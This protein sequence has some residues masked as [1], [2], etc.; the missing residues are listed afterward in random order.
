MTV[1]NYREYWRRTGN[2]WRTI[3][4]PGHDAPDQRCTSCAA[5]GTYY[6]TCAS[7]RLPPGYRINSDPDRGR[8]PRKNRSRGPSVRARLPPLL[9]CRRSASWSLTS[10]SGRTLRARPGEGGAERG[11]RLQGLLGVRSQG[12]ASAS[13]ASSAAISSSVR[14]V[15]TVRSLRLGGMAS[16]RR[17]GRERPDK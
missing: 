15:I 12:P 9:T 17:R 10:R 2:R 13:A 7:L 14:W 6:L 11:S 16:I 3:E 8:S 5:V 1:D 4:Q